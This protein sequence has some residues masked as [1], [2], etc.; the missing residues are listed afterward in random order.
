MDF[1]DGLYFGD[2]YWWYKSSTAG[3]FNGKGKWMK[4]ANEP[5]DGEVSVLVCDRS[6]TPHQ[7]K[8]VK[9]ENFTCP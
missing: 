1:S 2:M 4:I 3:D 6:T 5:E 7:V 8:W 9:A